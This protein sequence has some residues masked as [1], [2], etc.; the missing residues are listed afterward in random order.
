MIFTSDVVW[1]F[2]AGLLLGIALVTIL[3]LINGR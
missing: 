2:F 3:I 1:A